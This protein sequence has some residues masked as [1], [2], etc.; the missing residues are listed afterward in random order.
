MKVLYIITKSN[1]G[2][3]QRHVFDLA[4]SAKVAGLESVVALGGNG[5]LRTKLSDAGIRTL[6]I[7][8]LTRD[9]SVTKDAS[10]FKDIWNII[11]SE[12]PDIVHLHSPKAGGV[13]A[14]AARIY[15]IKGG[16]KSPLKK[17]IY[18]AHGWAWNENR[19]IY[20]KTAIAFFSWLTMILCTDIITLS[21]KETEQALR[22][23][24][25]KDKIIRIPLGIVPPIF[26]GH[27]NALDVIEKQLT[28]IASPVIANATTKPH[29]P[30]EKRLV[31]GTISEL[32][33]NKGLVYLIEAA[34]ELK[35]K[36]PT[37]AIVIIGE[38]ELRPTLEKLIASYELTDTVY[39]AGY[40]DQASQ[41]LKAFSIFTLT[42]L[43]EGLP[44]AIF[45]AA[46]A[47]VPVVASA[48]G[49]IPELI[50]DMTSGILIQPK[51]SHEITYALSF[52]LD[53][54]HKNEQRA[55]AEAL[56]KNI[57]T[58]FPIEKMRENT[59]ALY[60]KVNKIPAKEPIETTSETTAQ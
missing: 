52:L 45:E 5:I 46:Y 31:I 36:Y 50:T 38:G 32:H 29:I 28:S 34:R 14:L 51:K 20:Q 40:I 44:Y 54:N 56:R 48:V 13:G 42:S 35:A 11:S 43:K 9:V 21:I 3:A 33:P 27:K 58:N 15:K 22:F 12:K 24:W 7:G 41:Y 25:V 60:K 30:F 4:T 2:G 39:L 17:I 6:P 47:G 26:Y 57:E 53:P 59:F 18:T 37:L 8:A 16:K 19:P 10:S 23:P 49:G 1:W 55:Y